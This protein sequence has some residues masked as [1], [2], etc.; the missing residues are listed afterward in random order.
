MSFQ[1]LGFTLPYMR[2]VALC[3]VVLQTLLKDTENVEASVTLSSD[4]SGSFKNH[5]TERLV[6]TEFKFREKM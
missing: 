2:L 1:F 4:F 6:Q 5:D 3:E